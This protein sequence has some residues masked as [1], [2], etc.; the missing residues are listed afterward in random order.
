MAIGALD[1]KVFD[2]AD[3]FGLLVDAAEVG[4]DDF[5]LIF[6]CV[7]GGYDF[8]V[9]VENEGARYF[10]SYVFELAYNCLER[11]VVGFAQGSVLRRY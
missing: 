1:G 2:A 11:F 8:V 7:A 4:D 9:L 10:W 3:A 5:G 6:G